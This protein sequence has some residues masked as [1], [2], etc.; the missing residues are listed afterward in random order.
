MK[1]A[2]RLPTLARQPKADTGEAKPRSG[3]ASR[4]KTE[5][6]EDFFG[7]ENRDSK[8]ASLGAR[9]PGGVAKPFLAMR[10]KRD[11]KASKKNCPML[12]AQGQF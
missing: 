2:V 12:A 4:G 10:W 3:F 8:G 5:P 9:G 7:S 6:G 1:T 11:K